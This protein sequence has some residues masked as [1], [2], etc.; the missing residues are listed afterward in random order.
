MSAVEVWIVDLA[1]TPGQIDRCEA[2]LD[3]AER[4]RADRFLRPVDR[5]RF[6]ASHAA[7]RLILGDALGLAPADVELLAGAGGK[8]ELAGAARR[9]ADFNLSHSGARALIGLARDASIGV[10]V[11]A[12]RPIADALRIAAAHF[13]ADEVSALAGAPHGAVER[14]FFGLWTRKEAVVKALGSGLS[15]PLDRFSVSVPPRTA[16]PSPGF[17]RRVLDLD[18]PW[19][20]AEIDCGSDHVATV[21]VRSAGAEITCHRLS[22]D[23]PDHLG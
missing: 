15:L 20:L 6:R 18:G 23:W 3:A 10:D 7:L 14:R 16:A 19:S 21:A 13:A 12:V 5:A 4:G 8:P 22:D 1:L 11:E 9:A 17:R 2:V